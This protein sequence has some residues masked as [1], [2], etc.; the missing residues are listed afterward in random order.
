MCLRRSLLNFITNPQQIRLS[1]PE[2]KR[3]TIK[4]N[5][6][7]QV[8]SSPCLSWFCSASL[9]SGRRLLCL[10]SF[11]NSPEGKNP[12][13][14]SGSPV[15]VF[16]FFSYAY[17]IILDT[18][19]TESSLCAPA[20]LW[21]LWHKGRLWRKKNSSSHKNMLL[22]FFRQPRCVR[23]RFFLPGKVCREK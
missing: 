22:Y 7:R 14:L 13:R 9:F 21:R 6:A 18:E 1:C 12:H 19:K 16:R 8:R 15:A 17:E 10:F 23:A 4:K 2:K 3:L 11:P 5:P 20:S